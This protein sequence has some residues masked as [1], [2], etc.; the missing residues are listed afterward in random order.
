MTPEDV[1]KFM[2]AGASA[3]QMGTAF[4]T[5]KESTASPAHKR[6]LLKPEGH[7]AVFTWGFSGRPAQGIENEFMKLMSGKA[8]LPFPIQNTLT[9]P[10]RQKA[11]QDD[12]PEY[13]SLWCGT[14]F[15]QCQ[16]VAIADLML[17]I[18]QTLN[19]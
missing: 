17:R 9:G 4:L 6:Y 12:Q 10:I 7:R 2:D 8:I 1:K 19:Q 14:R 11:G 15:D 5:T 3:V 18:S 13:Q 16:D